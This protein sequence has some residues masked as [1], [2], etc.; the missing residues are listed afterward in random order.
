MSDCHSA[1][2]V[3]VGFTD[4]ALRDN[5]VISFNVWVGEP[6]QFI[7]PLVSDYLRMRRPTGPRSF[8]RE[9]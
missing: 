4:A 7:S 5:P 1:R 9:L 6:H 2:Y 3:S 8:Q